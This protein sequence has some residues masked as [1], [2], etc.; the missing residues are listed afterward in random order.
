MKEEPGSS[1]EI[2]EMLKRLGAIEKLSPKMFQLIYDLTE[3]LT[4]FAKL[5]KEM[6]SEVSNLLTIKKLDKGKFTEVS[7][8][9]DS[10]A[11]NLNLEHNKC[12]ENKNND[13]K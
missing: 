12:Y 5:K 4:T 9:L 2:L 1:R 10:I 6:Y 13:E 3:P 7:K 11:K 8:Y